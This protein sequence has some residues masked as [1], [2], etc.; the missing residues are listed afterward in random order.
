MGLPDHV[1][2]TNTISD[3][4]CEDCV[5][6]RLTWAPHSRPAT[7]MEDYKAWAKNA[8]GQ[9]IRI[10]CDD[11]GGEFSRDEWNVFFCAYG[12]S[13]EHSIRGTPQQP[14]VAEHFNQTLA[15]GITTA[16]SQL[17]LLCTWWE[18]TTNHFVYGRIH[19]PSC[20][21]GSRTSHELFYQRKGTVKQLCPFSCLTYVDL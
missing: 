17:G 9:R 21:I 19:L 15:E 6:V 8:M 11:K 13:C 10:L 20:M 4:F 14:G 16:L 1:T 3:N 7:H 12:I 5:N 18:D 2:D